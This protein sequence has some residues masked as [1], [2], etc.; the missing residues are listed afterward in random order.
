MIGSAR[1]WREIPQRYRYEAAKCRKCGHVHF[2]PR[3]V[4]RDCRG[5]V[6]DTVTLARTGVVET[7]TV[8]R[9]APSGFGDE[10][11]YAVGIV[12]LD[13]GVRLTA[14]I[15][16]TDPERLAIGERVRME[17]RRVQKDGESGVLC[18]GYKFV[19]AT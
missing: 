10:T 17:F 4:C 1:Y 18:Y 5:R 12:K 11:P 16:D 6:F 19:P 9:V 14:Q 15:V 3:L 13:D 2:P 8:I 7:F